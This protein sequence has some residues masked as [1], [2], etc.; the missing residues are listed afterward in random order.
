MKPLDD[1]A[2]VR[3]MLDA[4]TEAR[5]FLGTTTLDELRKNLILA[6]AIVRSL[7]IIG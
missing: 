2:R 1:V 3:H 7:E 5:D 4:A 6:N